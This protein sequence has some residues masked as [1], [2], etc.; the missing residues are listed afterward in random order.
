MTEQTTSTDEIPEQFKTVNTT[1]N[2]LDYY[3][4]AYHLYFKLLDRGII[5]YKNRI[6]T[7]KIKSL[8]MEDEIRVDNADV[9]NICSTI[10][11]S[12]DNESLFGIWKEYGDNE[13]KIDLL[14]AEKRTLNKGDEEKQWCLWIQYGENV[15]GFS[16]DGDYVDEFSVTHQDHL[17]WAEENDYGSYM[18]RVVSSKTLEYIFDGD[19]DSLKDRNHLLGYV[20]RE[21]DRL[22]QK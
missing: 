3:S 6:G 12:D 21:R 15:R 2:G 10:V 22:L 11:G 18:E 19:L 4:V 16:E 20:N 14:R 5:R 1:S 9:R 13:Y 8:L 7:Q 17:E